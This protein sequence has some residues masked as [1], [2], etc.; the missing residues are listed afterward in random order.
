[1]NRTV[2]KDL[3]RKYSHSLALLILF[4]FV[5]ASISSVV[6][7]F[8]SLASILH[9]MSIAFVY[10]WFVASETIRIINK[11][12]SKTAIVMS[13][14]LIL[15]IVTMLIVLMSVVSVLVDYCIYNSGIFGFSYANKLMLFISIILFTYLMYSN[16]FTKLPFLFLKALVI[17]SSVLFLFLFIIGYA[18]VWYGIT[19]WQLLTLN[20]SNPNAA[21]LVLT[22]YC[23]YLIY[24]VFTSRTK[25]LKIICSIIT[26]AL[27][28]LIY[29]TS[30]RNGFLAIVFF[31][32]IFFVSKIKKN[33]GILFVLV[34]TCL[35]LLFMS[36]YF[37]YYTFESG[38]QFYIEQSVSS[39]KSLASR[40]YVWLEGLNNINF[41]PFLGNYFISSKGTGVFHYHNGLLDLIDSYGIGVCGLTIAFYTIILFDFLC[42]NKHK[43]TN[44]ISLMFA[45]A[46]AIFSLAVFESFPFYS[47]NGL[48]FISLSFVALIGTPLGKSIVEEEGFIPQKQ[49]CD[50]LIINNVY[51]SGSTGKIVQ[52]LNREYTSKGINTIVI[53]GRHNNISNIE[54]NAFCIESLLEV[55]VCQFVNKI[56]KTQNVGFL[57]MTNEI[58]SV[59]KHLKPK[60]VHIHGLNDDFVNYSKLMSFLSLHKINTVYTNHSEYFF[61]GDC[62]GYSYDCNSYKNC[63]QNCHLKTNNYGRNYSYNVCC[64]KK[65]II[66][67]FDFRKIAVT[68]VS[69]WLYQNSCDS[70]IFKNVKNFV[71]IN[72]TRFSSFS[73][74]FY[75]PYKTSRRKVLY[76]TPSLDNPNK[77]F[78]WLVRLAEM[79]INIDFYVLSLS[80]NCSKVPTNIK[81]VKNVTDSQLLYQYYYYA[82]ALVLLSKRETFA[83]PVAESLCAGTPVIG[84][85]SGGPETIADPEYTHFVDYG[86][87]VEL[88]FILNTVLD[89][90][91]NKTQ[92]I[93]ASKENY[94]NTVMANRYISVY[95]T[96]GFEENNNEIEEIYI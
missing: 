62:G 10:A 68:S 64:R 94:S 26:I 1:M 72:G 88:N 4:L 63:C 66:E 20:F 23:I 79:N 54:R 56:L 53:F 40:Y 38:G 90:Y 37:L 16:K 60:I 59:I 36:V 51:A 7:K 14:N 43:F 45:F 3:L 77:G 83:M 2:L 9:K 12:K 13:K 87:I 41:N 24:F 32:V 89:S 19:E 76:V 29:L 78:N 93:N 6:L 34:L 21:S 81:I 47:S 50:V 52:D 58:I 46:G 31:F 22:I 67:S 49:Q 74:N 84:F 55:R 80:G 48:G 11:I 35:P 96:F 27:L 61:L 82:D 91:I 75:N 42:K 71:V 70:V 17:I 18:R 5:F 92:I 15:L 25:S 73:S 86:N 57:Y 95:K 39:S 65:N 30:S 33:N 28:A 8:D 85:K 69:P 44:H